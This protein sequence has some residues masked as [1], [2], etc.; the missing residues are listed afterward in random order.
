M[1]TLNTGRVR[2][3]WHTM[4]RTARTPRLAAHIAEP[5]C[6]ISFKDAKNL[7]IQDADLIKLE[8][9]LGDVVVRALLTTRVQPGQIFV[10]IHWTDQFSSNARID[11]LVPSVTDPVSGQPASKNTFVSVKK[12]QMKTYVYAI[13]RNR[14]VC[15]NADYWA[16]APIKNGWQIEGA[17]AT[18]ISEMSVISKRLGL[19]FAN[20]EVIDYGDAATGDLRHA[21]FEDDKLASYIKA[22]LEPVE[23]SRTW[24]IDQMSQSFSSPMQRYHIM[25]GRP[26]NDMPDKGAIVCS[27]FSVGSYEIA[28][29]V[30]GGSC[31]VAEIG[32]CLKAGTNCGSCKS[33]IASLLQE[34]LPK[35]AE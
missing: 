29:A 14:P 20:S 18:E 8:N 23:I 12:M 28:N 4:T 26:S 24:L 21:V 7:N 3:H 13:T 6:E 33:E 22:S 31:T 11:K 2:D 15:I 30:K 9:G 16:I 10:P 34:N 25:S 19:T 1:L 27:C 17:F 35:A 5:F 32:K